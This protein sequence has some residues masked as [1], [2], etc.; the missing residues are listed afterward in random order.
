MQEEEGRL[1]ARG[2]R[3]VKATAAQ[4]AGDCDLGLDARIRARRRRAPT[5]PSRGAG[6][7]E[8]RAMST[9]TNRATP[10][11][12]RENPHE[13]RPDIADADEPNTSG[14]GTDAARGQ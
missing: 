14:A 13:G 8:R 11:G 7:I 10:E 3:S 1:W 6:R 4:A 2:A 12:G 9:E 5:L